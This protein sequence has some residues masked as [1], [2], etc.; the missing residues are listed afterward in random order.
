MHCVIWVPATKNSI[1][2]KKQKT[3][4]NMSIISSFCVENKKTCFLTNS[5]IWT[6]TVF[7]PRYSYYSNYISIKRQQSLVGDHST[8]RSLSACIVLNQH[9][10]SAE[11]V[12]I[13]LFPYL[14]SDRSSLLLVGEEACRVNMRTGSTPTAFSSSTVRILDQWSTAFSSTGLPKR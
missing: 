9:Q 11:C 14:D 2:P 3:N 6:Y 8:L 1:S 12:F 5:K 7:R 10:R 4:C 13:S